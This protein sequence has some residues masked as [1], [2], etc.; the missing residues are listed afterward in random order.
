ML[1]NHG[2]KIL[3]FSVNLFGDQ[4]PLGFT[5]PLAALFK[6]FELKEGTSKNIRAESFIPDLFQESEGFDYVLIGHHDSPFY[7]EQ[8]N[9][10]LIEDTL[11]YDSDYGF[12]ENYPAGVVL[13]LIRREALPVM[14]NIRK[15]GAIR[16]DRNVF[17]NIML[18]D[19][20]LFDLENLY[21]PINL[22]TLRLNFYA[23]SP[24]NRHDIK[25]LTDLLK[26]KGYSEIPEFSALATLILANRDQFKTIPKYY[27]IEVSTQCSSSCHFCPKTVSKSRE[28]QFMSVAQFKLICEKAMTFSESP[29]L[30]LT[31]LGDALSHPQLLEL[32]E[33][34]LSLGPEILLETSGVELTHDLSNQLIAL[35]EAQQKKLTIILS[36]EAIEENLY[37]SL[38]PSTKA[39]SVILE[40]IEYLL[41]RRPNNTYVQAVKMIEN[42]EH[43]VAFHKHF[44]KFT[45]NI[46]IQKY[47]HFKNT[48]PERRLNAMTPIDPIDCW[49]LKRDM[50][51][52]VNGDVTVCKQDLKKEHILGNA[53]KDSFQTIWEAGKPYM[54]KHVEGWDYCKNC[55]EFYTYNY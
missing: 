8:E 1:N 19:V 16:A 15:E 23:E 7:S 51:I 53:L 28:S 4:K 52:T 34:G 24:Q 14:E 17:Q 20:N 50:V 21:A 29:V 32:L 2:M 26:G 9:K 22:R 25:T 10:R 48:L 47:N 49:H 38:R 12:G 33:V 55:D 37:E 30:C 54:K 39:F 40:Q 41:L 42:F 36:I 35:P 27:E 45:K 3:A 44:E 6:K 31:G 11:A 5:S 43:L 13:E 18:K 46:I